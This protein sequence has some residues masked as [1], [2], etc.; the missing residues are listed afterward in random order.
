MNCTTRR[1][2]HPKASDTHCKRFTHNLLLRGRSL[3]TG[4][5]GS[6]NTGGGGGYNTGGGGAREVYP[7]KG[8]SEKVLAM[9]KGGGGTKGFEVVLTGSFSHTDGRA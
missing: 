7:Y 8:G 9:L 1:S 3:I 4:R 5:E 2:E 6:Y